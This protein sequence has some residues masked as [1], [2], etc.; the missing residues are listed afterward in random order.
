MLVVMTDGEKERQD[1]TENQHEKFRFR[2][3]MFV[4]STA[5]GVAVPAP[6]GHLRQHVN[7]GH[8]EERARAKQH[9]K[10]RGCD[11]VHAAAAACLEHEERQDC[12]TWSS[13]GEY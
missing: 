3:S 6:V 9:G 11:R 10:A 13:Q 1:S 5:R 7:R 12:C 2:E 4:I 8:V